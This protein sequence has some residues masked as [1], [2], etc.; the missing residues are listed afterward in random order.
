MMNKETENET[1]ADAEDRRPRWPWFVIG[2]G[3]AISVAWF[4]L[5]AWLGVRLVGG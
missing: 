1:R 2:I 5:L 4:V 3:A